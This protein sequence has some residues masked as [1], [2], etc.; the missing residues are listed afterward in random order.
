MSPS[1]KQSFRKSTPT[2]ARPNSQVNED[3]NWLQS[4]S[5]SPLVSEKQFDAP[6][7]SS[8]APKIIPSSPRDEQPLYKRKPP[9]PEVVVNPSWPPIVRYEDL[10]QELKKRY[11][12][13]FNDR[14]S[15]FYREYDEEYFQAAEN[16]DLYL[17]H[18]EYLRVRA[19]VVSRLNYL[20]WESMLCILVQGLEMI[21]SKFLPNIPIKGFASSIY[22]NREQYKHLL[23]E[24]GEKYANEDES[25]IEWKICCSLAMQAGFFVVGNL[26]LRGGQPQPSQPQQPEKPSSVSYA[27][28]FQLLS[29]ILGGNRSPDV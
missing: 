26:L 22:Q 15:L 29:N 14:F 13:W 10:S 17:C 1:P 20:F 12:A 25:S 19:R 16:S 8:P 7:A 3:D 11:V 24:L 18:E 9:L 23:L 6:V 27:E 28:N 5:P 21:V 4:P 2:T